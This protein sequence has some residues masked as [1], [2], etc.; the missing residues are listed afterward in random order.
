MSRFIPPYADVGK[1]ITP[2]DGAK[3]WFFESGTSTPKN[4]YSDEALTTPNANPV[5]SDS[6]GVF[7]AIW[8]ESGKYKNRLTDK[9]DVQSR[10]DADPIE[11]TAFASD[12]LQNID[13]ITALKV[14]EP[15]LDG[16]QISLLGHTNPGIGGGA[17]Y[18][19][20]SDTTS[21]DNNGTIIVTSGG[22]RW[23]R[24]DKGFISPADFGVIGSGDETASL[25]AALTYAS[26]NTV[27]LIGPPSLTVTITAWTQQDFSYVNI[28]GGFSIKGSTSNSFIKAAPTLI[29]KDI[30]FSDFIDVVQRSSITDSAINLL[31]LEITGCEFSNIER[32]AHLRAT[33]D[34]ADYVGANVTLKNNKV[35]SCGSG[36]TIGYPINNYDI[37]GNNFKTIGGALTPSSNDVVCIEIG[38]DT[39]LDAQEN[40]D[41]GGGE[42][43]GNIADGISNTTGGETT[44]IQVFGSDLTVNGNT[45]KNLTSIAALNTEGI[46]VKGK[47]CKVTNNSLV[48][49]G[50][51]EGSIKFKGVPEAAVFTPPAGRII[52]RDNIVSGNVVEFTGTSTKTRIGIAAVTGNLSVFG[53]RV[54]N[55]N[56]RG[57]L[58]GENSDDGFGDNVEV[59]GNTIVSQ[60][61]FNTTSYGILVNAGTN[62][63][64]NN[65]I[66]DIDGQYAGS[67]YGIR[68]INSGFVEGRNFQ[69]NDNTISMLLASDISGDSSNIRGVVIEQASAFKVRDYTVNGN[70]FDINAST[71][72][73]R[74]ISVTS[75]TAIAEYV[76]AKNNEN[77]SSSS[78]GTFNDIVF[79]SGASPSIN[80]LVTDN[81]N[82]T[83]STN[84]YTTTDLNDISDEANTMNK[85]EGREVFNTST[86]RPVYAT[87]AAAA[88][89]WVFSDGTLAHTPV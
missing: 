12:S 53:N 76:T 73:V 22:K 68:A 86:N 75:S 70:K 2:S 41:Q 40:Q 6:N 79:G 16:H 14:F 29:I 39:Q 36:F 24:Q 48:D 30:V 45:G 50:D 18:Y 51:N 82:F 81:L 63:K 89:T 56:A 43:S 20:A 72:N 35:T 60:N 88:G 8:L 10:P 31:D 42:V 87:D 26:A 85:I 69:V 7:P 17:F 11:A 9:N 21:A 34:A 52:T 54:I 5:I 66:V 28:S 80:K 74:C 61:S 77:L 4:T 55:A 49:C 58:I 64:V 44:F 32:C 78:S 37:K 65:N 1:G 27:G 84:S 3:Y 83:S 38:Q 62:V 15:A 47:R 23:K 71:K 59:F 57:I 67:V 33:E 13:S 25:L 46:Y 19:D